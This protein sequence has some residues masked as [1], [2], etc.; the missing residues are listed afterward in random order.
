[1]ANPFVRS[2]YGDD[3]RLSTT[4]SRE[5]VDIGPVP[6][7]WADLD[8]FRRV[9]QPPPTRNPLREVP[10]APMRA[11]GR[12]GPAQRSAAPANPYA[13]WT[14]RNFSQISMSPQG[15]RGRYINPLDVP[16]ELQGQIPTGFFTDSALSNYSYSPTVAPDRYANPFQPSQW[17]Q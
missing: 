9:S 3:G 8:K 16:I 5:G 12:E 10:E 6:D 14:P 11:P 2:T 13:G 4:M 7:F 17:K 1:M 15:V